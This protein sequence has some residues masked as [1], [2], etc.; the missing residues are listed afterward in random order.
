MGT[1]PARAVT[2][3]GKPLQPLR[4]GEHRPPQAALHLAFRDHLCEAADDEGATGDAEIRMRSQFVDSVRNDA[5]AKR[6]KWRH[7]E[8][9]GWRVL[10]V[11]DRLEFPGSAGGST[12]LSPPST[13]VHNRICT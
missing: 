10:L 5:P 1:P 7:H 3:F 6:R 9:S 8:R 13:M 4:L 11:Q 12:S 2:P